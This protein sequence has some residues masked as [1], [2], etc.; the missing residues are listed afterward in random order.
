[1]NGNGASG[2]FSDTIY[3]GWLQRNPAHNNFSFGM[4]LTAPDS[5]TDD[6]GVIHWVVPDSSAVSGTVTTRNTV[7]SAGISSD[8]N[9]SSFSLPDNDWTIQMDGWGLNVGS[10]TISNFTSTYA[11]LEPY[12][13]SMYF[14]TTQAQQLCEWILF[15]QFPRGS[16]LTLR[17]LITLRFCHSRRP[18]ASPTDERRSSVERPV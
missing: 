6:G 10:S 18:A 12:F 5:G 8:N 13:P 9:T 7:A 2:E 17:Y 16:T 3:G 1:M 14:P 4:A 11:V 15:Y